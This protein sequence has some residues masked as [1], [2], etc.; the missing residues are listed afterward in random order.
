MKHMQFTLPET[1]HR[2]ISHCKAMW[3]NGTTFESYAENGRGHITANGIGYPVR[4]S[5]DAYYALVH[6]LPLPE[7]CKGW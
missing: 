5:G 3:D 6:G 7:R 4:F 1:A 2:W